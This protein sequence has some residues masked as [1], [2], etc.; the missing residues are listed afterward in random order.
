[1]RLVPG[2][3]IGPDEPRSLSVAFRLPK[4]DGRNQPSR[5]SV[6]DSF[7]SD[8]PKLLTPSELPLPVGT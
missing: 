7:S 5:P 8:S 2:T 3:K 6:G 4:F 1:M